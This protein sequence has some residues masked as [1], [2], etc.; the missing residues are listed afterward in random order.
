MIVK[1]FWKC[2]ISNAR[3]DTDDDISWN[4][5]ED[6]GNVRNECKEDEGTK[7]EDGDSDYLLVN[8]DRI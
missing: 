7:C 1:D 8:V 2:C 5:I 6:D 4:D 3:E